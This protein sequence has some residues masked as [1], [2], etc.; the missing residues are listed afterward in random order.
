MSGRRRLRGSRCHGA[1][2]E[3]SAHRTRP[4]PLT[5]AS[6]HSVASPIAAR[7]KLSK[8]QLADRQFSSGALPLFTSKDGHAF[9]EC[10]ADGS[11]CRTV[12]EWHASV[13]KDL[14][15]MLL[16]YGVDIFNAGHVHDYEVT[17]PIKNGNVTQLNY[18][19]PK[20]IVHITDGNGG[21]PGVL[22]T[23]GM[24][25]CASADKPWCRKHGTGGAYGRVI[26]WNAT[27][28]TYEHVQ[29]NG[30]NVTDSWTIVQ[31]NHGP[32]VH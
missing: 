16:K 9:V 5:T 15:P 6:A 12:G 25:D 23:F 2:G 4:R 22:G 17:W 3:S 32:F 7:P 29:N 19:E 31:H 27:H 11:P 10:P 13:A 1:S 14:E 20:G 24:T 18:I 30:G 26:A 21:V 8:S 28:L